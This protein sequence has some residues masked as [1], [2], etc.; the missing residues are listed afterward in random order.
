MTLAA[1]RRTSPGPLCYI[2]G[3][4]A[5]GKSSIALAWAEEDGLELLSLDSR[6][7][8]RQ[9]SIGTAKPRPEELARVRHHLVDCLDL[10]EACSAGRFR[11]L[12]ES[13]LEDVAARGRQALAV[14]GTGF[15][16][17]TCVRG[18][19]DLPASSP[20]VRAEL[21]AQ[22]DRAGLDQLYA[23]LVSL[24]PGAADRVPAN[25]RHRVLRALELV[26]TT[27]RPLADLYGGER[28]GEDRSS[29]PVLYLTRPRAETYARIERRCQAMLDAGL[30]NEIRQLLKAGWTKESPGLQTVGYREFFSFLEGTE[31]YEAAVERFV[32]HSRRYAKRQDT[33][34]RNRVPERIEVR[35]ESTDTAQGVAQRCR[36]AL[37][38]RSQQGA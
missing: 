13:A 12:F 31:S 27:G 5:V 24:D 34:F 32:V 22:L 15:Y 8:Y 21:E 9:L 2:A 7:V 33:W 36:R 38:E 37:E 11:D 14:G 30:L 19:H 23:E 25:N 17:E 10:D 29:V 6:Q 18:L 3:A 28:T 16:W 20:E 4:T 1:T 35:I 26:R